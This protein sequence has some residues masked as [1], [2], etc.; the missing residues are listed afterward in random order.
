MISSSKSGREKP[1]I[2]NDKQ[3]AA[4][5]A[6]PMNLIN[7]LRSTTSSKPRNAAM[8]LF[9]RPSVP[10]IKKD[11]FNPFEKQPPSALIPQ[12]SEPEPTKLDDILS[13]NEAQISLGLAHDKALKLLNNSVD[14]LSTKLDDIKTDKLPQVIAAA[15]KVVESIRKE[16]NESKEVHYHFYTPEQKKVSDYEVIDVSPQP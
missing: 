10:E 15:S 12:T 4:R 1:M 7:K 5:L 9:I 6:S 16:R 11:S 3:A 13:N 14:M 8:S 2:V